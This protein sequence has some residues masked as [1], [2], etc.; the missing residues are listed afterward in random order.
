MPTAA[1][2]SAVQPE[3]PTSTGS[4]GVSAASTTSGETA[5]TVKSSDEVGVG[6]RVER[7]GRR[8]PGR[9]LE[10][11]AL[12]DEPGRERAHP[13]RRSDNGDPCCHVASLGSRAVA[14]R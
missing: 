9:E 6:E 10:V 5:G 12:V 3:V 2:R 11:V 14:F 1:I 4:P 7:V 13:A 8:D